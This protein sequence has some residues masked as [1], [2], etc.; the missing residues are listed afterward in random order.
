MIQLSIIVVTWN[1]RK[2]IGPFLE[3]LGSLLTDPS[4]QILVVDN[5]SK[6]GTAD[7]IQA[8]FP[9]VELVRSEENLGFARGNN[10]GLRLAKGN[11]L[12]LVN[13][14][15]KI[16]PGCF[17]QMTKWMRE[18]QD[19]GLLG[20]QMYEGDGLIH[21]STMRFPTAWNYFCNALALD[22]MFPNSK[23]FR[24]YLTSD[25]PES[26]T[27]DVEVLNG[28]FWMTRRSALDQVGVL[29]EAF[30][31]YGEDIDWCKRFHNAGWKR[32]Y[33]AGASAIHYGGGSSSNAPI[34]F[35]VEQHRAMLQYFK[36]H[37]NLLNQLGFIGG[38]WVYHL[39]RILGHSSKYL[40]S[41]SS[42]ENLRPKIK[43]SIAC[44]RWLLGFTPSIAS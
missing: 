24:S 4:V 1:C 22:K 9:T 33:F 15:V 31:M 39:V 20:P 37:L 21:R 18:H 7:E 28:W 27:V 30:F 14:D 43:R 35:Y 10:L 11:L 44:I 16:L 38:L 17:E 3:S 13:P 5:A 6:D 12:A 40:I 8:G 32:V 41:A 25:V 26:K 29:D 42:H 34:R 19:I 36:K 23:L 2:Y